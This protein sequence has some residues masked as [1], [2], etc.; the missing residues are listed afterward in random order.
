VLKPVAS[1][2]RSGDGTVALPHAVEVAGAADVRKEIERHAATSWLVQP[3][4]AGR[5]V[6]V[7]GV[8]WHGRVVVSV[9]QEAE[10]IFPPHCGVSAFARTVDADSWLDGRLAALNERLESHGIWEAQFIATGSGHYLIDFN[11]RIYGSLALAVAAG[12]NLPAVWVDL[13][14]GREPRRTQPQVGVHFR[15]EPRELGLLAAAVAERD[16]RAALDVLRPRRRTAHAVLS[17]RDPGPARLLVKRAI[18]RSRR[19]ETV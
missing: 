14:L 17:L 12:A 8:A 4:I 9:H 13:L 7:A 1:A 15:A 5:L 6:A 11:P 3:F 19:A 10:R 18:A 2:V 16:V